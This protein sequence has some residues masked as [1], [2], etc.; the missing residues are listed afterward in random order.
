MGSRVGGRLRHRQT[1]IDIP[2]RCKEDVH[3]DKTYVTRIAQLKALMLAKVAR[4]ETPERLGWE[5]PFLPT[6]YLKI[7]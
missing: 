5:H 3:S 4:P 2:P 6:H 7:L 1:D